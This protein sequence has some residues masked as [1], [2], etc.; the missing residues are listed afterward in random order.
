MSVYKGQHPM[1]PGTL[2]SRYSPEQ[3]FFLSTIDL[4]LLGVNIYSITHYICSISQSNLFII[5]VQRAM[6]KE[7]LM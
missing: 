5:P 7:D 3:S 2:Y 6:A 1:N 4:Q